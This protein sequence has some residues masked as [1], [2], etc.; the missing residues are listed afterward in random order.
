MCFQLN[1]GS[2]L[3]VE[4]ELHRNEQFKLQDIILSLSV[5]SLPSPPQIIPIKTKVIPCLSIPTSIPKLIYGRR[6][7]ASTS[8]TER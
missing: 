4:S 7:T 5:T 2:V 1:T 6:A 8:T 3:Y